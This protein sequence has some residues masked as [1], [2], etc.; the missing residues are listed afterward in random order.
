LTGLIDDDPD[1]RREFTHQETLTYNPQRCPRCGQQTMQ[2]SFTDLSD[3]G[4]A[5]RKYLRMRGHRMNNC[6]LNGGQDGSAA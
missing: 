5:E 1:A 6:V 4:S 2:W 3:F